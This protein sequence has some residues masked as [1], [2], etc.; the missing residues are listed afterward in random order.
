M[1]TAG[2]DIE[3]AKNTALRAR[4]DDLLEPLES[5][6]RGNK[7]EKYPR[8]LYDQL[9]RMWHDQ[10]LIETPASYVMRPDEIGKTIRMPDGTDVPVEK[11]KGVTSVHPIPAE[12]F[13]RRDNINQVAH[14]AG[15][16]N[17]KIL[18]LDPF[19]RTQD[20]F[21]DPK[22]QC[23][24]AAALIWT[25]SDLHGLRQALH[26]LKAKLSG[27]P[28]AL[29]TRLIIQNTHNEFWNPVLSYIGLRDVRA[30]ALEQLNIVFSSFPGSENAAEHTAGST[31][32][33]LHP[34]GPV[35]GQKPADD[36]FLATVAPSDRIFVVSGSNHK[37]V[38]IADI[39]DAMRSPVLVK[40]LNSVI[41]IKPREAEEESRTFEGNNFEKLMSTV[42]R[43]HEIGFDRVC[44]SLC[45]RTHAPENIWLVFDDRG[46]GFDDPRITQTKAFDVVRAQL[47]PY[48]RKPAPGAELA[49]V[50]KS[51]SRERLFTGLL[52]H[53]I[54][55]I[56]AKTGE[57][58]TPTFE[59]T[60]CHFMVR[61]DWIRNPEDIRYLAT[62]GKTRSLALTESRPAGMVAYSDYFEAPFAFNPPGTSYEDLRTKAQVPNYTKT[63]SEMAVSLRAMGQLGGIDTHAGYPQP[64]RKTFKTAAEDQKDHTFR[65][66]DMYAF[67]P[68]IKGHGISHLGRKIS[69]AFNGSFRFLTGCNGQFDVSR[70]IYSR[71]QNMFERMG[72]PHRQAVDAA[73]GKL[74]H[75][76][77]AA[78]GFLLT[79]DSPQMANMPGLEWLKTLVFFSLIVG[80]QVQDKA[81]AGKFF[82]IADWEA[83]KSWSRQLNLARYLNNTVLFSDLFDM[84]A[85]TLRSPEQKK[86]D[87]AP[88]LRNALKSHK[89]RYIRPSIVEKQI[90]E[91]EG[92]V[93]A[94]PELY[95]V[96]VYCSATL[97]EDTPACREAEDFTFNLARNGFALINGGG[98]RE[99]TMHVT[100]EGVHKFRR[101]WKKHFSGHAMPRNHVSS[102]QC[103]DTYEREGGWHPKNEFGLILQNIEQRMAHLQNTDAEVLLAGGAGS[104][105]EI[106]ASL[107]MR[108]WGLVPTRH[109]PLVIVN[110]SVDGQRAFAPLIA[111][112]PHAD[113]ARLN[114]HVVSTCDEALEIIKSAR[115]DMRAEAG[116]DYLYVPQAEPPMPRPSDR[117]SMHL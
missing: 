66:A 76:Y 87:T 83:E 4:I 60:A 17:F 101:W 116:M 9:K 37:S 29:G 112:I 63:S 91:K 36:R 53:A 58:V 99:G 97:S 42:E 7:P 104:V 89:S 79:P 1:P 80:K 16:Y 75:L 48:S 88:T 102:F 27:E 90:V 6:L 14:P 100:S 108:E 105:Q 15:I 2:D 117:P 32:H 30:T 20:G 72:E 55:E 33:A 68:Q 114:I 81:I 10:F 67:F 35:A 49:P 21:S 46:F 47:N 106:A 50:F 62:F 54:D 24:D 77:T 40:P 5:I 34:L 94:E 18:G 59:D 52:A 73:L 19:F 70:H 78:D 96:T 111:M 61:L 13:A 82:G 113:R 57:S 31:L 69:G 71:Q 93:A 43:I 39:F 115:A 110:Q 84:I 11:L 12:L 38:E 45:G 64:L 65:L 103:F 25:R 26:I 86:A 95:R 107:L 109:R 44:A 56:K 8:A 3:K 74:R 41:E 51:I 92:S 22:A 28:S 85:T 98:S 23:A